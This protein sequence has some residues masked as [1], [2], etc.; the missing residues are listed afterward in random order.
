MMA[1]I[2]IIMFV[3]FSRPLS[4]PISRH[5]SCN[6]TNDIDTIKFYARQNYY[7]IKNIYILNLVITVNT[8][9]I[10]WCK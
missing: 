8:V 2:I 7:L 5:F 10:L 4:R 3:R 6:N 1:T 9:V